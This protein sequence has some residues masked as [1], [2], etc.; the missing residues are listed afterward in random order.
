MRL[1]ER[2]QPEGL[3]PPAPMLV[4]TWVTLRGLVPTDTRLA[5]ERD[6][7]LR[8]R[9]QGRELRMKATLWRTNS[10]SSGLLVALE[11]LREP[12]PGDPP[13][14]ERVAG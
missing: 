2:G 10:V 7:C 11:E 12:F 9:G 6:R 4:A 5:E 13:G 14:Q 1:S 8:D 3:I